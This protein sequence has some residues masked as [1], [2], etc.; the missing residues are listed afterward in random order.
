MAGTMKV[1]ALRRTEFS[2]NGFTIEVAQKNEIFDLPV[3]L[4]DGLAAEKFVTSDLE[5]GSASPP[6]DTG[7]GEDPDASNNDSNASQGPLKV[8]Q[9]GQISAEG[10]EQLHH[11]KLVKMAREIDPN[12]KTRAEALAVLKAQRAAS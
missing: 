5:G 1:K 2:R 8:E 7:A 4:F 10:L 3:E 6:A 9:L 12:I 11:M